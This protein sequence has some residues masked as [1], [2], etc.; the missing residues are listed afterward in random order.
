M[1]MRT[2]KYTPAGSRKRRKEPF[3]SR[4][5]AR[6]SFPR[7]FFGKI[8]RTGQTQPIGIAGVQ[9]PKPKIKKFSPVKALVPLA[10]FAL[11]L[12]GWGVFQVIGKMG[13][14]RV[15]D[16]RL[17]GAR[18]ISERQVLEL[19]GL[20]QGISLLTFNT[21]IAERK[22]ASHPWV[23]EANIKKQWP[24]GVVVQVREFAPFAIVNQEQGAESH[25]LRY[26]DYNGHIIADVQEGGSLDFPVINGA[27]ADEIADGRLLGGSQAESALHLLHLAARGNA[28]LPLQS[29]SEVRLTAERGLIL[30]LVDHPFPIHF[31]ND[32]LQNKFN[33]LLQVLKKLYD[34]GEIDQVA[35]LELVYGD[36]S[37]K[38]L[39]RLVQAK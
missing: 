15:T 37:N 13:M 27:R 10:V 12:T 31:G 33:D 5:A 1:A 20:R 34:S 16:I 2:K 32:R 17:E 23:A 21:G 19:T 8:K 22:I 29:V 35:A 36:N 24:S 39:C 28:L 26:I 30:Y 9:A 6:L 7:L 25:A 14:F 18:S 11:F 3:W 4:L 38:M